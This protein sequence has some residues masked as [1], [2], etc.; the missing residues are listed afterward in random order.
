M[1]L[2]G[3]WA[4]DKM[5]LPNRMDRL[6]PKGVLYRGAA[7][8]LWRRTLSQ[9]P[10]IFGRLVYLCSLR[11][12]NSGVYEHYGL[13]QSFGDEEVNRVLRQSHEQSFSEWL[14]L[15][16][17]QQL[18]DL[19]LYLDGLGANREQ[20]V[21][22]WQRLAPYRNLPPAAAREVERDLYVTDI[23]ALLALLRN[24]NGIAT[25]DPDA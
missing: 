9:I 5:G 1:G 11:D 22:T 14:S 2:V 4:S 20:I 8:D 21:D 25:A 15:S 16:L 23:E 10:S 6:K 3:R 12:A 18:A 13:A 17:Q 7:P 19:E 24:Q